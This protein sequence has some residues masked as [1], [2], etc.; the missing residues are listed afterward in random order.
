MNVDSPSPAPDLPKTPMTRAPPAPETDA[1]K[2]T[3][4]DRVKEEGN[5]AFKAKRFDAAIEFYT[6]A[7][8]KCATTLFEVHPTS[9]H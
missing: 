2:A 9:H 4:A 5:T 3:R 8:G 1:Q 6:K 7:I